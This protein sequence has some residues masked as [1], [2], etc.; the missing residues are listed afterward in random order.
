MQPIKST[1]RK[2]KTGSSSLMFF[3][4]LAVIVVALVAFLVLRPNPS[5]EAP[6]PTASPASQQ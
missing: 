5:G 4:I 6:N 1:Q 3:I 2:Y